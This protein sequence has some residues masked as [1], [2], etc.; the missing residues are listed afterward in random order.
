MDLSRTAAALRRAVAGR[1]ALRC[2]ATS[3][4]PAPS[5]TRAAD[6]GLPSEFLA[7]LAAARATLALAEGD[8]AGR[9]RPRRRRARRG[10]R[11]VLHAAAVLARAAREA[12]LAERTGA[13]RR[14][15]G[16]RRRAAR[17][18]RARSPAPP[19]AL[20]HR[21]LAGAEH[22]R[23][24]ATPRRSAGRTPRRPSTRSP[25]PTRPP[26]RG[27]ARPRRRCGRRRPRRGAAC[28]R[29]RVRDRG[30]RSARGR[31]V[32]EIEALARR[33]RLGLDS[34][35]RRRRPTRRRRPDHTRD[36]GAPAARRWPH[37]PR[38]RRAAVHQ[39]EDRRRPRGPHLRQ[40][41][42]A[43]ARRGGRPRAAA[44]RAGTSSAHP[45]GWIGLHPGA[46]RRHL[47]PVGARPPAGSVL[48]VSGVL[49][50]TPN[51]RR[52]SM[53]PTP[54]AASRPPGRARPSSP[55]PPSPADR[56][57]PRPD[58]RARRVD[59]AFAPRK[60]ERSPDVLPGGRS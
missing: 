42:R 24:T 56:T 5:S 9:A 37:Q 12:E 58:P 18:A 33:A 14:R 52:A 46:A 22:A 28:A 49:R 51:D 1:A 38:D 10:P 55:S 30:A 23:S 11:P 41:R 16:A 32:S 48:R 21:A 19:G 20:A 13:P 59:R 54:S 43:L 25:S 2:A 15:T 57:D 39:P 7:P 4:A 8:A 6:A 29:R 36:R 60:I 27:C 40:A 26:T 53:S 44:W 47:W 45:P 3:R 17:P 35:P 34:A 31:C 50:G